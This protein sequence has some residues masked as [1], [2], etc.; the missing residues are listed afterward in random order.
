MPKDRKI[1][2][3]VLLTFLG[4]IFLVWI[5]KRSTKGAIQ[6]DRS[7][8]LTSVQA[9]RRDPKFYQDNYDATL[10]YL[11]QVYPSASESFGKLSTLELAS[12]YNSLWFYY[13]CEAS[14]DQTLTG[15]DPAKS[16]QTHLCWAALPGCGTTYAKLPY[17]PQG[18]IYSFKT[19]INDDWTP[20]F[21]SDSTVPPKDV[22][23]S[24]PGQAF[25]YWYNGPAPVWMYQRAIFR[26]VYDT[27][28]MIT[29]DPCNIGLCAT[30]SIFKGN[31]ETMSP[32]W[33]YPH[34]W[35]K[36]VPSGGYIEVT[37]ASEPGIPNSPPILW[38]DGWTGSGTFLSV[39]NT[40]VA[41]NKCHACFT[42]CELMN[43]TGD[44]RKKLQQWFNVTDPYEICKNLLSGGE[45]TNDNLVLH[46]IG[47]TAPLVLDSS[48]GKKVKCSFCNQNYWQSVSIPN[49]PAGWGSGIG[50]IFYSDWATWCDLERDDSG[51]FTFANECIDKVMYGGSYKAD[52][53][54]D[55]GAWDEFLFA[56]GLHLGFDTIQLTNSANGVGFWQVEILELR[57]YPPEARDRDYSKFIQLEKGQPCPLIEYI[58]EF[59]NQYMK[60]IPARIL[61]LRDPLDVMNESK[62]QKC[63]TLDYKSED[64]INLTCDGNISK[65]FK[66]LKV[67]DSNLPDC[68]RIHNPTH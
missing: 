17:T 21:D 16:W 14:F 64:V 38:F 10:Q 9:L 42:M 43:K 50:K 19:W 18:Y 32:E 4:I 67:Q 28:H 35:W 54:S 33:N 22:T 57:G 24:V 12:F 53:F 3:I 48:T 52:R 40:H 62:V 63:T 6:K 55:T 39:G 36:G 5:V 59:T 20:F 47:V 51:H 27:S 65:M 46:C 34:E 66:N 29:Q 58:P 15:W 30:P 8:G 49:S 31:L 25:W 41:R 68:S 61:S 11:L 1:W 45:W 13:N 23:G 56:M 37:A 26:Y 2:I 60:E 7:F 44:G